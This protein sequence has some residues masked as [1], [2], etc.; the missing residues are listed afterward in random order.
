MYKYD[1]SFVKKVHEYLYGFSLNDEGYFGEED[2]DYLVSGIPAEEE[3]DYD[4]GATKCVLIPVKGEFVI[5][6][7]FNGCVCSCSTCDVEEP[8][9][10]DRDSCPYH[11]FEN[12]GGEYSDD[13]CA[14]EVERYEFI[15]ENYP[16]FI[17][18]FLPLEKIMEVKHYPV[19]IQPKCEIFDY[20][21]SEDLIES[22]TSKESIKT[23]RS[24]AANQISA[25]AEW[26]AICFDNLDKDINKYNRFITMLKETRISGDL[27]SKN[28]GFYKNHA[29]IL[30]YAGFYDD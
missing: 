17:D 16:E 18:F 22:S 26:L 3:F 28:L 13:Y 12:G 4:T 19:Y 15:K 23:V 21:D 7:P 27:H 2:V 10:C 11:A 6:I 14:L 24:D 5:K 25:P 29:I 20:L 8:L 1:D 9:E 30:D